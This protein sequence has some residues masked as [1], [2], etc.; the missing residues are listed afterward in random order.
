MNLYAM[1]YIIFKK[2]YSLVTNYGYDNNTNILSI[3]TLVL[4]IN[5]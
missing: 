1:E 2:G 4:L 5:I 3:R